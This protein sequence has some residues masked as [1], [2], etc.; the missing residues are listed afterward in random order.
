METVT[1]SSGTSCW[2]RLLRR[3]RLEFGVYIN[4]GGG[5]VWG[6]GGGGA[7]GGGGGMRLAGVCGG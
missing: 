4:L 1:G 3:R 5:G 7:G 2:A 6:G